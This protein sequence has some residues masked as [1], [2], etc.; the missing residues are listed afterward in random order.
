MLKVFKPVVREDDA[1]GGVDD[2]TTVE[3]QVVFRPGKEVYIEWPQGEPMV[4]VIALIQS[5]ERG[6]PAGWKAVFDMGDPDLCETLVG[7]YRLHGM[8][9]RD[10][11]GEE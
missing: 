8:F 1:I 9:V 2:W 6:T 5:V 4:N 7:G 11:L 10:L 3:L